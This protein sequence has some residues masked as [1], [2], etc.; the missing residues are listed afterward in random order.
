MAKHNTRTYMKAKGNC[1]NSKV[2]DNTEKKKV[3]RNQVIG[4]CENSFRYFHD[5]L[6]C[7][8][9]EVIRDLRCNIDNCPCFGKAFLLPVNGDKTSFAHQCEK[10]HVSAKIY[11]NRPERAIR[12]VKNSFAKNKALT[13]SIII[14][15]NIINNKNCTKSKQKQE[16][17]SIKS[18]SQNGLSCSSSSKSS[19]ASASSLKLSQSV[20]SAAWTPIQVGDSEDN[21]D[22]DPE[23]LKEILVCFEECSDDD[24]DFDSEA[25]AD[26]IDDIEER[27]DDTY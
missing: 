1:D 12:C 17:I 11:I 25:D 24:F 27:N 19:V 5:Y 3:Q 23:L 7:D 26:D 6:H 16:E 21:D 18:M 2:T 13:S 15:D 14:H 4:A 10:H 22:V 8:K 9:C 20:E